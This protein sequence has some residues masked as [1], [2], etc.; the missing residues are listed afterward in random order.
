MITPTDEEAFPDDCPATVA[1]KNSRKATT[2]RDKM[3]IFSGEVN[4]CSKLAEL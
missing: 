4:K 1:A 3:A 2:F